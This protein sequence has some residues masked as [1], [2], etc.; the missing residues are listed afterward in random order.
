MTAADPRAAA[1]VADT[2]P[3]RVGFYAGM[4]GALAP[5]ALFVGG[6]VSIGLSGA[7]DE[8][9]F[10]PV[11]VAALSL[12]LLLARDRTAFCDTVIAGM[13]R[14]I[15]MIM[16]MAW[17]LASVLGVLLSATS[18]IEALTWTAG[19]LGLGPVAFVGAT[20]LACVGVSTATGTSFGTILIAGPLLYPAG[21][22]LGADPATTIGAILGGAVFGDSISPISDTTIASAFSQGA[23][24]AG[25]VRSRVKYV[26]PAAAVSLIAYL[27]SAWQSAAAVETGAT[28]AGRPDGLVMATVPVV[29]IALLLK[30]R[31]LLHGLLVGLMVGIVV[32]LASGLLAPEQVLSIDREN[33][34]ARSFIIDG[35]TRG[36]GISVFT[37]FLLGLVSTLEASGVVDRVMTLTDRHISTPRAAEGWIVGMAT[38]VALLTTHSVVAILTVG[39]FA[40]RTG[41]RFG[42]HAYRRANLLDVT[43]CTLPFLLPYFIP[44]I[45]AASVTAGAADRGV[46]SVGPLATGLHN[47]QSWALIVVMLVAVVTG[48]GRRFASDEPLKVLADGRP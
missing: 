13:S 45:L 37:I 29:V 46:P 1:P 11:L 48:F 41:A 47:F 27:V 21:V 3:P 28:I 26:V 25:T 39:E 10:W 22:L 34:V 23:D 24:I 6:V 38:L 35:I 44:V 14:E 36:L 32:G 12:G 17:L 20:F 43:V 4:F 7:P 40:A 19:R 31:H 16:V 30:G 33:F 2:P 18:F 5:F 8:R 9:G 15:V 42:I